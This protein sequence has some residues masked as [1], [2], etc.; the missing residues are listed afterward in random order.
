MFNGS[1]PHDIMH[2]VLEGV[3]SLELSLLLC[4]CI[5]SENYLSLEDYNHR[6][7]LNFR[8]EQTSPCRISLDFGGWKASEM[9]R[10]TDVTSY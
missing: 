1:L 7:S 3:A 4:H 5:I 9:F 10:F 2:D 8:N 6:L